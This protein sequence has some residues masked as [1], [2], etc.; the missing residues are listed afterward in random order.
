MNDPKDPQ[1][2]QFLQ[3]HSGLVISTVSK[4]NI[5]EAAYVFYALNE[6]SELL[7][8]TDKSTQK[9]LNIQSNKNVAFVVT[10]EKNLL[11]LQGNGEASEILNANESIAAFDALIKVITK[12]IENWPP[13]AG[14]L[15]DT[16][17]AILK[18]TPTWL[19]LRDYANSK[20]PL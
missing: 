8:L 12:Q 14:K 18:I 15:Q 11:T 4:D 20:D 16:G 7:I 10:D 2:I 17:I 1:A 19:R 3:Q 9:Y 6:Q 5:L 13:P